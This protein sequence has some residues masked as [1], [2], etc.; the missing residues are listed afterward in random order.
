[1]KRAAIERP[2]T[3]SEWKARHA[4]DELLEPGHFRKG[5]TAKGCPRR[6]Y[7]CRAKKL[8]PP[9]KQVKADLVFREWLGESG[10]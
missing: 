5:Q 4:E 7:H 10:T 1:M 2:R 6:C 9:R 3:V 8:R